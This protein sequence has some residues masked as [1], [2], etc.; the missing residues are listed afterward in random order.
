MR[1]RRHPPDPEPSGVRARAPARTVETPGSIAEKAERR[2]ADLSLLRALVDH[3]ERRQAPEDDEDRWATEEE[4]FGRM[5]AELED[6]RIEKLS[7]NQRE[8]AL[9]VVRRRD[10]DW[11]PPTKAA[12]AAPRSPRYVE[13]AKFGRGLVVDEG[14]RGKLRIDF[15]GDVGERVLLASFVTPA[16]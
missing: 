13:H 12:P 2:E 7:R 5:L 15:G 8:W 3:Y 16:A 14:E 4:A 1:T 10:V 9:G 11:S 6:G